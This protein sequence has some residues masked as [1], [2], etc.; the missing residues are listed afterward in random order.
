MELAN[1]DLLKTDHTARSMLNN[2]A[3]C[4]HDTASQVKV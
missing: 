2:S 3:Q 4:R 1:G